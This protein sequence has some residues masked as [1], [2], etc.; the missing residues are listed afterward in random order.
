MSAWA[1]PVNPGT[2]RHHFVVRIKPGQVPTSYGYTDTPWASAVSRGTFWGSVE[3]LEGQEFEAAQ[4]RWSEARFQV[5]LHF[6]DGQ[7][8]QTT[9]RVYWNGRTLEV[10]DSSDPPGDRRW[11]RLICSEVK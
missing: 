1:F 2:F 5:R 10:L 4:R 9:D 3:A 8:I 6:S 11:W 7:Y